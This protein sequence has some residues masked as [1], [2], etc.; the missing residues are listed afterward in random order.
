MW[1]VQYDME[2]LAP[3]GDAE[4]VEPE[5]GRSWLTK[6]NLLNREIPRGRRIRRRELMALGICHIIIICNPSN[7]AILS[8]LTRKPY[9]YPSKSLGH[10]L[11][12]ERI[13]HQSKPETRREL[14][15]GETPCLNLSPYSIL[16]D[17]SLVNAPRAPCCLGSTAAV[18]MASLSLKGPIS[19]VACPGLNSLDMV[20]SNRIN[21]P[22][23]IPFSCA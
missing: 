9:S 22:A 17:L 3:S 16:L 20:L 6:Q 1:N 13:N 11:T 2:G 7:A 14:G 12:I 8:A 19:Y 21:L 5:S 10:A 4:V 15:D 18:P 23:F